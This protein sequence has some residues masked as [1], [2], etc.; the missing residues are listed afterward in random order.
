MVENKKVEAGQVWLRR[1]LA[2]QVKV[3]KVQGHGDDDFIH[4]RDWVREK[5][6]GG[7]QQIRLKNWHH[8]F[9]P[10]GDP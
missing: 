7:G 3:T 5:L 1:G 10:A 4:Y 8:N 9:T 2:L 6:V